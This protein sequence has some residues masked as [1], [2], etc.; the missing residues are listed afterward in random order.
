MNRPQHAFHRAFRLAVFFVFVLSIV[1]FGC[2]RRATKDGTVW[3]DVDGVPIFRDQVERYYR[4][5]TAT[6]AEGASQEQALSFKLTILDELINNQILAAH[7]AKSHVAVSEAEID[8]KVNEL[9][10]PYSRE[11][12]QKKLTEQGLDS[13]SLR[14]EIRRSLIITKLVNKEIVSR[15][16]VT[17]PEVTEY[18]QRNKNAFNIT[19][20]QFHLAQIAVTPVADPQVRNTKNDDATNSQAAERKVQALYARL[21]AGDDFA[22]VAQEYSEDARTSSNGGDM[23]F[24]P[25]SALDSSPALRKA[26]TSLRPGEMTPVLRTTDGFHILKLLGKEEA[27]QRQI[28]DPQVQS[29]IRQTLTNEREQLLRAAYLEDLHNHA[30]VVNYLAEKVET[31]AA[32]PALV[33]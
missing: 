5:R 30:K 8:T 7:A 26:I 10:S 18:Y 32:N 2:S 13:G 31:G 21:R 20:T 17:D 27:G 28:S 33:K 12:F 4:S 23:G 6:G 16:K 1:P 29:S 14:D 25:A 24:L 22:T 3:A 9:Q 11:E 15:I 19:E